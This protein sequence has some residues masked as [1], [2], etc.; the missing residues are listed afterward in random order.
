MKMIQKRPW[1]IVVSTRLSQL[2]QE[3]TDCNHLKQPAAT[4]PNGNSIKGHGA[5]D[6]IGDESAPQYDH[7][8][9]NVGA[10][11]NNVQFDHRLL[12]RR[13]C[14]E[15][16][17]HEGTHHPDADRHR[18]AFAKLIGFGIGA[19]FLR[20]LAYHPGL[21]AN[22][23]PDQTQHN[24]AERDPARGSADHLNNRS[25]E[26]RRNQRTECRAKPK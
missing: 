7:Q 23:D 16:E 24:A 22:C 2:D 19:L 25:I 3:R 21:A 1:V 15:G 20:L 6:G 12:H 18:D 26:Q 13:P 9:R 10:H 17:R 11:G 8:Q 5:P 4:M 14:F